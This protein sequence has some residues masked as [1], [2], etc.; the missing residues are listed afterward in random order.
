MI[1]E[2]ALERLDQI[3][4]Q[5]FD[6]QQS[7]NEY[8]NEN[9]LGREIGFTAYELMYLFFEI[10][11]NFKINIPQKSIINGEFMTINDIANIL[12]KADCI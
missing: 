1:Y 6:I 12:V 8:G 10:E 9:L 5:R 4:K 11:K 7:I 2:E 3:M